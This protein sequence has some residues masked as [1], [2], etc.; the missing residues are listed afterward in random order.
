MVAAAAQPPPAEA[1]EEPGARR[2]PA[3]F[4]WLFFPALFGGTIAASLALLEAGTDPVLA[5]L[6]PLLPAYLLVIVAERI[7]PHQRRWLESR[8]DL[9]TDAAWALTVFATIEAVRPLCRAVAIPV[10]AFLTA[11]FGTALWPSGWPLLAQLALALV[12]VEF[13]QYWVH[14]LEHEWDWLWRFHATHHSAPRLYW[15]NAAR[16]HPV[17][18]AL[19]TVGEFLPLMMLGAGAPVF[20]LWSLFSGLHGILQHANVQMQLGPLNWL[21]SMAELH[22]WHHSRT[23]VESNTNYGQNLI[24]W[25]VVFGTRFLPSDREPPAEIGMAG[26]SAFPQTWWAQLLS[27]LRWRR[28]RAASAAQL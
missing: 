7:H 3:A 24:V 11:R 19:N 2:A 9:P 13:F 16:F 8:G 25:D 1:P 27:P 22:R 12:V 28:I 4:R 21:F 20:A 17:D 18:M 6:G 15:L 5:Y 10:G 26:L 14:R 23:V